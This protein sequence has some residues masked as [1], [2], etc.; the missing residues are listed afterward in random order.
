MKKYQKI[1]KAVLLITVVSGTAFEVSASGGDAVPYYPSVDP[2]RAE[3]FNAPVRSRGSYQK[4]QAESIKVQ[5][6]VREAEEWWSGANSGG[7]EAARAV[8]LKEARDNLDKCQKRHDLAKAY[9]SMT[10]LQKVKE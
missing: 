7:D 5:A 9:E 4:H 6:W 10:L 8:R 1:L 2:S 3:L